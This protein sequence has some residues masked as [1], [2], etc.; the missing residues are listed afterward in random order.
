MNYIE[1]IDKEKCCGCT[2]CYS[3]C[4][5]NAIKMKTDM[6]GFVYPEV[7]KEK[8]I[9]CG[10]CKKICP[11]LK[12]R[13]D[14]KP[15]KYYAVKNKVFD[16]R[17]SS[18]SGGMF[19]IIAK[20]VI[21]NNG[22]VY[23]ACFDKD[24]NVF[25]KSARNEKECKKFKGSKY[26]QSDL[27]DVFRE[28]KEYLLKDK[29]VLFT[30]TPCQISGIRSYL[31]SVDTKK[32]IT[33]DIVCHGVPSPRIW[34]EYLKFVSRRYKC[35]IGKINFRDKKNGWHDS[36]LTIWDS[37]GKVRVTEKHNENYFSLLFFNHFILRPSC[38][39]CKY[40]SLNRVG[41]IT[42]GDYWG[43]DKHYPDF[44]DNKG[45]S[46]TIINNEK[47]LEVWNK[48]KDRVEFIEIKEN[49]CKQPNLER[50]SS[51]PINRSDFWKAYE[52]FG[53]EFAG[54]R[55]GIIKRSKIFKLLLKIYNLNE[56]ISIKFQDKI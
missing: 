50:P 56:K 26:V 39:K 40:S 46:L 14:S 10:K 12:E 47:G 33:C 22:V 15:I 19:S 51:L 8:C 43:I 16:I 7:D 29:I 53:F 9:S 32:L 35:I 31:E 6:E 30:G 36:R 44:D 23:G 24:F 55:V 17:E 48:I 27:K 20:Y 28:V 21:N 18:S 37:N 49:E 54:K 3:V 1:I 52:K 38:Y 13:K 45:V 42:L 4:P 41:D 5:V 25:H 2:A 34:S 11:E